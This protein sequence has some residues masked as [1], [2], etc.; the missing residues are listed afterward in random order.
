MTDH[1]TTAP[2]PFLANPAKQ[3]FIDGEWRPSITGES[4][5]TRNPTTGKVLATLARGTQAD[6]DAAVAVAR[7]AF[8]GPWSRFTPAQR[9]QLL[10]KIYDKVEKHWDELAALESLDMGAPLVRLKNI[11]ERNL[12]TILFFASQTQACRGETIPN[13]LPGNFTTMTIKAPV[14][15]V[16]GIIPWN[17]PLV[18]QWWI[19]GGALATGC[20]V[21]MKPAEDASLTVLRLAELLLEAGVPKGVINV[22]TGLGSEAGAALAAHPDVD[23]VA[24]TGSTATGREIIKASAVNMKRL[25]L[26]LGGKSP[27]IIFADADLDKAV[28][29]A[30]MGVFNNSGQI[31]YSGTRVFVQRSIQEEFAERV[32]A[33][34]K[35]L[36]VGSPL[37][38]KTHMGPLIS[39]RQLERVMGYM[40]IG[41]DEGATLVTGGKRVGGELADGYFVEPTVFC[42]VNNNMRIAR[43]EIFGPVMS[44]I[45]F[46][47]AEEALALANDTV[48]GLGGAVWTQNIRTATQMIHGIRAGQVWVNCYGMVDTGVG[49][50]GYKQS[51]YGWKGG[52]DHVDGFL[53]QKAVTINGD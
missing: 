4:I 20:T 43:E 7:K 26:E 49:F 40:T 38:P 28:P 52:S 22:V 19:L 34:S 48:Y 32:A 12:Q 46:D 9:H 36:N 50:G 30:A 8:E 53:Y 13:S 47:T 18:S 6:V 11:K 15:V 33:F 24:F 21:V 5:E 29:G 25:S 2:H 44:V 45:P 23:R 14:G 10:I 17:G 41:S 39:Q 35:T 27:D 31:C 51:G 37:D 1:A 16:G 42:N 3:H